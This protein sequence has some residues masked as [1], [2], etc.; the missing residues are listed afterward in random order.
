MNNLSHETVRIGDCTLDLTAAQLFR[1]GSP[2]HV[3]AKT[4]GVLCHFARHPGRVI[5]KEELFDTLWPG[6]AVTEE[7]LT[8]SIRELRLGWGLR[9]LPVCARCHAVAMCWTCRPARR[10]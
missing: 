6:V 8:Q 1:A 5:G 4:F 3:R 10:R 9:A 7:T 2:L